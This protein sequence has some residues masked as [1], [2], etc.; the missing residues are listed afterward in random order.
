MQP[1]PDYRYFA[2]ARGNHFSLSIE[3]G[4]PGTEVELQEVEAGIPLS[5]HHE[6]FTL[7]FLLPAGGIP[8]QALYQ[9]TG[10]DGQA[11]QLLMTPVRP[12]A[13]GRPCLEAV[14]HRDKTEV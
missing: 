13:S 3:P 6:C 11:W 4:V 10:P 14:I 1:L 12:D 7:L 9:L 5:D 8:P 2:G